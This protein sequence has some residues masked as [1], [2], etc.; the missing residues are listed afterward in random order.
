MLRTVLQAGGGF[1]SRP[2]REGQRV[3]GTFAH[4][5]GLVRG[6]RPRAKSCCSVPRSTWGAP[7]PRP[8]RIVQ[9]RSTTA[10]SGCSRRSS[11]GPDA[12]RVRG[13]RAGSPRPR[14]GAGGARSSTPR[15][16]EA[17]TRR[18]S[19]GGEAHVLR[20]RTSRTIRARADRGYRWRSTRGRGGD[21]WSGGVGR[22]RRSRWPRGSSGLLGAAGGGGSRR[23]EASPRTWRSPGAGA[24]LR[25]GRPTLDATY[26]EDGRPWRAT[27][28]EG[29]VG[30]ISL[31]ND[32]M[33]TVFAG[34]AEVEPE[35]FRRAVEV[36][37]SARCGGMEHSRECDPRDEGTIVNVGSALAFI[38]IPLQSATAPRRSP[39]VGSSSRRARSCSTRAAGPAVHGAPPGRANA[40]VR[41][42]RDDDE[43]HP[44]RAPIY[45]PELVPA[46][47]SRR[48]RRAADGGAKV[49]VRGNKLLVAGG[50]AWRPGL[51]TSTRPRRVGLAAHARSPTRPDRP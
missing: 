43:P 18:G 17:T 48:E 13:P 49:V 12:T 10:K 47:G 38:G 5:L 34:W 11:A 30:P 39:A 23:G 19:G 51:G 25:V 4:V 26:G 6:D 42:G 29:S 22:S 8:R 27:L 7:A 20:R 45:Q 24:L 37:F 31:V 35:Q 41:L 16:V 40:P 44:Q 15:S 33:T 2:T 9:R 1:D 50:R 14:K 3:Y 36:T 21:R 28:L 32:A 46:R